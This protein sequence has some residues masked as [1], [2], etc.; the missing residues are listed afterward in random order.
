MKRAKKI[1]F[2]FRNGKE[3]EESSVEEEEL[4][5]TEGALT[6][7][8]E[9][10]GTGGPSLAHSNQPVSHQSETS[11]LAIM[12]KLNHIMANL[13]A[14]SYSEESR[15]QAFKTPSMKGPE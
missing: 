1:K 5:G 9:S 14:A 3:E 15:P 7:V 8:G 4:Y 6:P 12:Q 11:L 10:Q 2:F 13:Q